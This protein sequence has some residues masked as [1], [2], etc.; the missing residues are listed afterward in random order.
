M[1]KPSNPDGPD[2]L[3]HG[4][5]EGL[6]FLC[7]FLTALIDP[8]SAPQLWLSVP[9]LRTMVVSLRVL[10]NRTSKEQPDRSA[11]L[12]LW[13]E[14]WPYQAP[15]WVASLL[16][17]LQ[18][19]QSQAALAALALQLILMALLW[20]MVGSKHPFSGESTLY[21]CYAVWACI[22]PTTPHLGWLALAVT[23]LCL[24]LR[25]PRWSREP[26]RIVSAQQSLALGASWLI[27][28]VLPSLVSSPTLQPRL[29]LAWQLLA[30]L[31]LLLLEQQQSSSDNQEIE[32]STPDPTSA[33][34][35]LYRRR[36]S[37]RFLGWGALACLLWEQPDHELLAVLLFALACEKG[38][39]LAA[40]RWLD[41]NRAIWWI[42]VELTFFWAFANW[43]NFGHRLEVT[44]LSAVSLISITLWPKR[45]R[46]EEL[47]TEL[48]GHG[49]L[50]R[51]L[52]AELKNTAPPTL[53]GRI[54]GE[55]D[56]AEIEENLT[57]TAPEGFR[58]R[59]LDRLRNSC[60]DSE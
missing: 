3:F 13:R 56:G 33:D 9:L 43:P 23:G 47:Q 7:L 5:I 53:K 17:P 60:E 4:S 50:E 25:N 18:E 21:L 2:A 15:F 20:L 45:Q 12:T 16:F 46:S 11:L 44:A 19:G 59:L 36:I 55:Y 29:L 38:I 35:W 34:R 32:V 27:G 8:G 31:S 54:L 52:R 49:D 22:G 51:H 24:T 26:Q 14:G 1:S 10:P 42:S 40:R 48:D 58:Q 57:A 37:R 6:S 41:P 28:W 39:V 30:I